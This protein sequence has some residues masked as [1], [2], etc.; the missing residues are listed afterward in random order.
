MDKHEVMIMVIRFKENST[1]DPDG[2]FHIFEVMFEV[3]HELMFEV[4]IM[5]I[6]FKENPVVDPDGSFHIFEHWDI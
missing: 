3:M 6:R 5:A 4:M 1:V 2:S